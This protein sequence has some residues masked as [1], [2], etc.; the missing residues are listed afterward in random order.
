MILQLALNR[1]SIH[2]NK[3]IELSGQHKHEVAVLLQQGKESQAR[4]MVFSSSE[5]ISSFRRLA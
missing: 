2:K 5:R 1:L 3:K 4:I